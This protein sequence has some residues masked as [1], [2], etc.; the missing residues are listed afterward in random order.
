[1]TP[2][3]PHENP[4]LKLSWFELLAVQTLA[5]AFFPISLLVCFLAFGP[6][7]T[8]DLV[9]ALVRDWLQTLFILVVLAVLVL[10]G[11]VW[12]VLSWLA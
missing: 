2:S 12:G 6:Q 5:L 3:A 1:M 9:N 7:M 11:V 8:R 4:F 10:S